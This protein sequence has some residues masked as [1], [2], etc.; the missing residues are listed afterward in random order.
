M[1]YEE[2]QNKGKEYLLNRKPERYHLHLYGDSF[3][4]H[5]T[6]KDNYH[7][8]KQGYLFIP[9]YTLKGLEESPHHYTIKDLVKELNYLD[10]QVNGGLYDD[11]YHIL[12]NKD[13][14]HQY[15]NN[16]LDIALNNL[17]DNEKFD[18]NIKDYTT[19]KNENIKI[20][21][22]VFRE[23]LEDV[24][25]PKPTSFLQLLLYDEAFH[26]IDEYIDEVKDSDNR[27]NMI[28]EDTLIE[29]KMKL[30]SK[31]NSMITE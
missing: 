4:I 13:R 12:S 8:D 28:R 26:V 10:F 22:K 16:N 6:I 14:I 24:E 20:E 3:L 9:S 30:L 5:D 1:E 2:Y 15:I 23:G 19:D 7:E 21:V 31:R 17:I 27:D 29:L 11:Y 18:V 25:D